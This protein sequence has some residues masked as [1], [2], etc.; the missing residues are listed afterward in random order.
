MIGTIRIYI[1]DA[2]RGTTIFS[3][4][5]EL[6]KQQFYSSQQLS[7]IQSN[8]LN[9][10]FNRAT[11][12]TSYYKNV[13]SY[14][15]L[16]ILT[17]DKVRAHFNELISTSYHKKLSPK[18]T[19]GSTGTPLVY[20]TT[21]KSRSYL[22][23]GII[24]SWEVAGYQLGDKV[25]FIA[26]TSIFKKDVKHFIFH[27][28]LNIDSYSTYNLNDATIAAYLKKLQTSH[29][30]IIYGYATALDIIATYINKNG[31][32]YFPYLK[33]II[34]TAEVLT[35][36]HRLNIKNAF[37]VNVYNQYGCNEAGI[38][39]FE[40]EYH[41]LHLINTR[42]W[43]EVDEQNNLIA[44]DLINEGFIMMKYFTGDCVEFS[45]NIN[46]LCKRNF[47]ILK[48][49][50]GRSYDIVTDCNNNILHAAFFNILFRQDSTIKQ[51]Q[52]L[53]D[54]NSITIYLNVD[55]IFYNNKNYNNYLEIIKK[56]LHFNEYKIVINA[57]F[58]TTDNAK[59]RYVIN[60]AV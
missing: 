25:A 28:I 44:T 40:C 18:G 2:V 46:C 48:N 33:G 43:Y 22:W 58:L 1:L 7:E 52:I 35:E 41:Q 15:C 60:T 30:K 54:K 26:G 37:K 17:K 55:S 45:S 57:P 20:L 14:A 47:P 49:V 13:S 34:S 11:Q 3:V 27:K 53:F 51:F 56:Q 5:K 50:I 32:F 31:P 59:H 38:S 24:L 12:T 16:E 39:A 8:K 4:L 9:Q 21:Q 36:A 19:G 10:L 29:T 6:R 42:C 23:A